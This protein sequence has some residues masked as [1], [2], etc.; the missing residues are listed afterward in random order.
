MPLIRVKWSEL[1]RLPELEFIPDFPTSL[2]VNDTLQFVLSLLTGHTGHD[3]RLLRCDDNGALLVNEAWSNL[4]SVETDELYPQS[5]VPD[6][7]TATV[8]NK[9]VLIATSTQLVRV[10]VVRV[11]SGDAEY[12]YV[13]P[14]NLY[15]IP[16]QVY[17][18][19]VTPVP[20][21]GGTASYVG[22][23]AFN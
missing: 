1:L 5:G 2:L 3:R 21:V 18:I 7:F 19:V 10:G 14:S 12:F 16:Y 23:T 11:L 20:L 4:V 13:P 22:I 9:G 17:S 15:W 8:D 6:G